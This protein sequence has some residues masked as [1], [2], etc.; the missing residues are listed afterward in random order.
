MAFTQEDLIKLSDYLARRRN[1]GMNEEYYMQE[2]MKLIDE[3]YHNK[4]ATKI[5]EYYQNNGFDSHYSKVKGE[6]MVKNIPKELF[7]NI[8]EWIEDKPLSD[9]KYCGLSVNDIINNYE[10]YYDKKLCFPYALRIM[11]TYIEDGCE[12]KEIAKKFFDLYGGN[13]EHYLEIKHKKEKISSS[14]FKK[15]FRRK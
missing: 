4:M 13:Y 9:I 10:Y 15:W 7:P 3:Y 2:S 6:H 12:D 1:P 5:S 8:I 11:K 14:K